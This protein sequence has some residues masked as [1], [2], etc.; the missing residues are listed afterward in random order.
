MT[1]AEEL[2]AALI[3][4]E[5]EQQQSAHFRGPLSRLQTEVEESF[6]LQR[7]AAFQG[8]LGFLVDNG[9]AKIH[10]HRGVEDYVSVDASPRAARAFLEGDVREK[11]SDPDPAHRLP[12]LGSYF[13]LGKNWLYEFARAYTE[14]DDTEASAQ[15]IHSAAWTGNVVVSDED[16][17]KIRELF[18]RMHSQIDNSSL[19]NA[20]KANALAVLEALEALEGAADP[21]WVLILQILKSPVLANVAAIA[22]LIVAIVKP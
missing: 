9:L 16:R 17:L 20:E 3:I 10:Q 22:A 13:D 21:P 2:M 8:G 18:S 5:A 4:C 19:T 7:F 14:R 6:Q 12:I 11:S 15:V 1:E